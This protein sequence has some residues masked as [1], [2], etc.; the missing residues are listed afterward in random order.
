[1]NEEDLYLKARRELWEHL[2]AT[3]RA[4]CPSIPVDRIQEY[5]WFR[6]IAEKH[7]EALVHSAEC[8]FRAEAAS[9]ALAY[10]VRY[11]E[12]YQSPTKALQVVK[13]QKEKHNRVFH[14]ARAAL[15][16]L[17]S[18]V[19]LAEDPEFILAGDAGNSASVEGRQR[20]EM[21]KRLEAAI[22]TVAD[23]IGRTWW[24]QGPNSRPLPSPHKS[25][26]A[27]DQM[28]FHTLMWW[29]YFIPQRRRRWDELYQVACVWGVAKGGGPEAFKHHT[30]RLARGVAQIEYCPPWHPLKIDT[31]Q[32]E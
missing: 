6:A 11:E 12:G 30:I 28:V 7:S 14:S 19:D 5:A 22:S 29:K 3:A 13:R 17:K 23:I 1:M 24:S 32:V 27:N 18:L 20:A 21:T 15:A 8:S 4:N 25:S 10:G 26:L 2:V 16:S 9:R 31:P